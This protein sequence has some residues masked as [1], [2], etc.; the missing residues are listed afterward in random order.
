MF[1]PG[2]FDRIGLTKNNLTSIRK[3]TKSLTAYSPEIEF[4]SEKPDKA[5]TGILERWIGRGGI[6]IVDSVS[7]FG[8]N[9]WVSLWKYFAEWIDAEHGANR[10]R[11]ILTQKTHPLLHEFWN[12][13]GWR[14]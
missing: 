1:R 3:V 5:L 10:L 4:G 7:N 2:I 8:Q 12:I 6:W 13:R 11:I 9:P 14:F